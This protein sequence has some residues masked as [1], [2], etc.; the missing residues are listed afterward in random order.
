VPIPGTKTVTHVEE[1]CEAATLILDESQIARL[2]ATRAG[3]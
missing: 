3:Q 2:E 1:N